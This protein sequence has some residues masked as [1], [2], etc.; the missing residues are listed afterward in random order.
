MGIRSL[1]QLLALPRDGL[2]RRFGAELLEALDRLTGDL[3]AGLDA[4]RPPDVFDLR[5]ELMHE[6]ENIAS[7]VFPLRRITGDLAAYLAGR[8][9]GVQRF[10]LRLELAAGPR[11]Q[12]WVRK[13]RGGS[14]PAQPVPIGRALH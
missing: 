11:A 8:D 3:P 10:V 7:L 4:Y 14:V 9:G 12:V 5:I 1:G 6:V 13:C 2:R